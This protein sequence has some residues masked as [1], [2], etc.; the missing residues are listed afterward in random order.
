M[1]MIKIDG[2]KIEIVDYEY[3]VQFPD[4]TEPLICDDADHA[5]DAYKTARMFDARPELMRR[6]IFVSVWQR[7]DDEGVSAVASG[8]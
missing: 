1:T 2:T 7:A 5:L 3:G 8:R 6:T 4:D